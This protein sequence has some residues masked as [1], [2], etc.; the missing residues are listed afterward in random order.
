MQVEEEEAFSIRG[1][2]HFVERGGGADDPGHHGN[3]STLP[4][5][6]LVVRGDCHFSDKVRF[7]QKMG[8]KAVVVGDSA[9]E[10][11]SEESQRQR[12]TLLNMAGLGGKYSPSTRLVAQTSLS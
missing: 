6:A 2:A 11:E 10:G 4:I 9:E 7:A 3:S 12:T 1:R 5:I 8:A